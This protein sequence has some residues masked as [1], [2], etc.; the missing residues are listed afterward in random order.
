MGVFQRDDTSAGC[1]D[2]FSVN[3][4]RRMSSKD[5]GFLESS[6]SEF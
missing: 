2:E 3:I 5:A 6:F 4:S 1:L